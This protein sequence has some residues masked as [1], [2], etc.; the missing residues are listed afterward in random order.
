VAN[1]GKSFKSRE[2]NGSGTIRQRERTIIKRMNK[3]KRSSKPRSWNTTVRVTERSGKR[4]KRK[5]ATD[6]TNNEEE[7]NVNK[8]R[9]KKSR[10]ACKS[11]ALHVFGSNACKNIVL[12]EGGTRRWEKEKRRETRTN[13]EKRAEKREEE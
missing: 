12:A 2:K 3:R 4:R 8:Q 13:V 11:S 5:E 1:A 9:K 10:C 7:T 6:G